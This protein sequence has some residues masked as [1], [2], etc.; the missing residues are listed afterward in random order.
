MWSKLSRGGKVTGPSGL[1]ALVC[2]FLPWIMVS[3]EGQPVASF[4]GWQLAT[5]GTVQTPFGPQ[6]TNPSFD[7]L[8]VLLGTI[9]AVVMVA[10]V[11]QSRM[12]LRRA[13]V[14]VLG[15]AGL[16]L[17]L[18]LLKLVTT[19]SQVASQAEQQGAMGVSLDVQF[20]MGY[21]LVV[22]AHLGML[23]G[24]FMDLRSAEE[25]APEPALMPAPLGLAADVP[26]I[27][28]GERPPE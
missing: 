3:C 16:G 9:A 19:S 5:G 12:A 6:T 23:A 27:S 28:V 17:A 2:F 4:S 14:V 26:P 1:A 11:Y 24:A 20:Q 22:L 21:W 18:L 13:A 25:R 7:M 8:L 10:L 15:A